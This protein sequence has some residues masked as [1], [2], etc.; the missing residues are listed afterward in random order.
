MSVFRVSRFPTLLGC[1][2]LAS[3]GARTGLR[4]PDAAPEGGM[5]AGLDGGFDAGLDGGFDAGPDA[6]FCPDVP[7]PLVR[8]EVQTLLL[9]DRSGSMSLTWDGL[10]FGVGLPSRWM[11][12]RDTLDEVLRPYDR[13]LS[14]GVKVFPRGIDCDVGGGLDVRPQVGAVDRVLD[15]FDRWIP[16]GGTPAAQALVAS[17]R[18]LE[19]VADGPRVIVMAMDGGPNC[20]PDP[21]VAP[22]MCVCTGPRRAC[23]APAPDGP[24]SCLDSAAT[25]EVVRDAYETQ[26]VPV[27]VVGIDDPSRP[28]LSDFLDEMAV[29]GGWPRPVGSERRFYNAREP[30]DLTVAFGEIAELISRCVL[31]APEP[32]PEGSTVVVRLDG[33]LV[34]RDPAHVDGWDWADASRGALALFGSSCDAFRAGDPDVT[35]EITCAAP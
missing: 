27:V 3:C 24:Q 5:D 2:L 13:E 22:D 14:L 12:M 16:E 7:V 32:P 19:T 4:I 35:A 6:A 9:L 8:S 33:E 30:E 20:N 1:V 25:L 28:D 11:I 23:L 34:P 21:G 31:A 29:A 15:V 26:G 10:P 17:L 18:D